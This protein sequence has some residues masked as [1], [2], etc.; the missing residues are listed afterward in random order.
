[1]KLLVM[2]LKEKEWVKWRQLF[3]WLNVGYHTFKTK[4]PPRRL[5]RSERWWALTVRMTTM[6]VVRWI[7]LGTINDRR[8]REAIISVHILRDPERKAWTKAT[9]LQFLMDSSSR[10]IQ[11]AKSNHVWWERV[12][13]VWGDKARMSPSHLGYK[14]LG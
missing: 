7:V 3:L 13:R 2:G 10:I 1:M 4:S 11:K 14:G 9:V 5:T 8:I 6:I 12:N